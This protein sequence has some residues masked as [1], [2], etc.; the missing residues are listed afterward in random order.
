[1]PLNDL[2]SRS[3]KPGDRLRKPSDG[4]SLQHWIT[5]DGARRW[6]L[7]YRFAGAL[8]RAL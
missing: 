4:G 7:A 8:Q 1:M 6:R 5:P 3:A 2:E